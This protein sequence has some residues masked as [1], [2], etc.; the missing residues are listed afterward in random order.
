MD[1][2]KGVC[3]LDSKTCHQ[4][5]KESIHSLIKTVYYQNTRVLRDP[6]IEMVLIIIDVLGIYS[7]SPNLMSFSFIALLFKKP[8][9][10]G[11]K[12]RKLACI[13]YFA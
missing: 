5:I 6:R 13:A 3:Y 11:I 9:L 4:K 2:R 8:Y 1:Y 7:Q 12:F 10:A